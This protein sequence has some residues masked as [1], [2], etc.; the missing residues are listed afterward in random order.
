MANRRFISSSLFAAILV[1]FFMSF[2]NVSCGPIAI[3]LTGTQLAIGGSISVPD[4][5]SGRT[6]Q[7]RV[8]PEPLA[9]GAL[10]AAG[11]GLLVSL[12]ANGARILAGLAGVAGGVLLLLLKFK[13][14]ADIAE[15]T[16]SS[17]DGPPIGEIVQINFGFGFWGALTL[18]AVAALFNFTR[19]TEKD[20]QPVSSGPPQKT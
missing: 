13:I 18:F 19:G 16:H 11:L 6:K 10:I 14:V 7:Q 12:A 17:R 2:V 9:T 3:E 15:S 1:L 20:V 5:E 8:T 4:M